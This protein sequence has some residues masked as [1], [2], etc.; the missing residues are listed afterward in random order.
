MKVQNPKKARSLFIGTTT[1]MVLLF[2]NCFQLSQQ[3]TTASENSSLSSLQEITKT[4]CA[5]VST[6]TL[7]SIL[8]SLGSLDQSINAA[9]GGD[10][11]MVNAQLQPQNEGHLM[12]SA[13]S[14]GEA[15]PE[16][17]T[18][19][20]RSCKTMKFKIASELLIDAC[21]AGLSAN[22]D[23]FMASLFPK[24]FNDRDLQA[25]HV[26]PLFQRYLGR[27]ADVAEVAELRGLASVVSSAIAPA[28]VCGAVLS[29]VESLIR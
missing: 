3:T 23:Q 12:R 19:E 26:D 28:A 9:H 24:G 17:D 16:T 2:Q 15:D 27:S 5:F 1:A 20:D 22:R 6:T 4:N 7:R 18:P 11:R 14:L 10:L 21:Q 8:A 25:T 29:S 13:A